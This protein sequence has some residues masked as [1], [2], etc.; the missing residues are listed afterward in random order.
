[1]DASNIIE[2]ACSDLHEDA[3]DNISNKDQEELQALLD[4][5]C[6]ENSAGTTSYY[7]DYKVG[8]IVKG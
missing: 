5:W 3:M 1:M 6:E 8:I 7:A 4:K 2:D